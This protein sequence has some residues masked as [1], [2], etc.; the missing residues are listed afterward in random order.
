MGFANRTETRFP[1]Q[2]DASPGGFAP[3][4]LNPNE[5]T[6]I[7]CQWSCRVASVRFVGIQPGY[8][9]R[10]DLLLFAPFSGPLKHS[11]LAVDL[12]SVSPLAIASRLSRAI[13]EAGR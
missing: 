3:L 12:R 5:L 13:A 9:I 7:R 11:T 8:C 6:E 1:S 10:P 2:G 4:P